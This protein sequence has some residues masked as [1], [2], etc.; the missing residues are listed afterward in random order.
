VISIGDSLD[1]KYVVVGRLGGGGFG[2]VF[3]A[4]DQ[5]IPG[6]QVGLKV[7]SRHPTGDH[8]DLIWEMRALSQFQYPGVVAFHHH[9][10]HQTLLVLAMEFCAGGSLG[11]LLH[12]DSPINP[13]EVF[14]WGAMLCD[15]LAFVH[16]KGI[17]HHDIKPGNILFSH[18][19]LVKIGDFGV[20]NRNGGT[21]LYMSPE[22]L[23]WA[24]S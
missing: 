2:E 15:T 4:E 24:K 16:G 18:D 20:A 5:A 22:A 3:L 14:R 11:D 19:G 21:R 12:S 9:F 8:A 1:G 6:R 23:C 13:D 7:L 10:T 17:V